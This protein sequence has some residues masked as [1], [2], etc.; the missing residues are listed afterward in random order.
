MSQRGWHLN[1]LQQP[2]ALHICFTA[3]HTG[4]HLVEKLIKVW[5]GGGW[6]VD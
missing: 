3:A 6:G 2:A 4:P 5:V 1:A